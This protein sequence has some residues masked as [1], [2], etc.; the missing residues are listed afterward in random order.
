[1]LGVGVGGVSGRGC[2]A[3]EPRHAADVGMVQAGGEGSTRPGWSWSVRRRAAHTAP[4]R[5][6]LNLRPPARLVTHS[7]ES[8]VKPAHLGPATS[9]RNGQ[10]RGPR[11]EPKV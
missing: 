11:P 3:T 5:H 10:T 6:R 1:M 4:C 7:A 8:A 2:R 9:P